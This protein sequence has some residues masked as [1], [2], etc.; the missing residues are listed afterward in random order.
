MSLLVWNARGLCSPERQREL[1]RLC[2]ENSIEILGALETKT[3]FDRFKD[4]TEMMGGEWN[5]IRNREAPNR[6]SIWIG[7]N[8]E[9]W[10]G[11]ILQTH[12]QFIHARLKNIGG[13]QFDITV[14]YGENTAIKKRQLWEGITGSRQASDL[15]DWLLIGDFNEIRHP[16]KKR[17]WHLR[18][19]R[20]R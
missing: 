7:W 14:V 4:A 6:D 3:S 12:D 1:R 15:N 11:T 16:V 8:K 17:P 9:K 10:S 19:S 18:Q 13:Y 20:C 2:N 5:I